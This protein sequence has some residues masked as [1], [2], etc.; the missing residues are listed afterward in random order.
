[1][2][3][4]NCALLDVVVAGGAA[5]ASAAAN[6]T[7]DAAVTVAAAR[8]RMR[9]LFGCA[10]RIHPPPAESGLS[11]REITRE[12]GDTLNGRFVNFRY[13]MLTMED[14]EQRALLVKVWGVLLLLNWL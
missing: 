4:S 11:I 2:N 8:E 7:D 10:L 5:A 6:N 13:T 3:A 9:P 1:M 12:L 14:E